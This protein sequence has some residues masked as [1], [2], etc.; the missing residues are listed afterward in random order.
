MARAAESSEADG[1]DGAV[2]EHG[3]CEFGE[4]ALQPAARSTPMTTRILVCDQRRELERL[5]QADP[6][7]FAR[8]RLG[9]E[10][11][12]TPDGAL[13]DRSWMALRG[14]VLPLSGAGGRG[15]G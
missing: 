2:V 15:F 6:S 5:E 8:G 7:H 14:Q 4:V 13:K 3:R 12:A 1:R 10:E 11:V 9:D